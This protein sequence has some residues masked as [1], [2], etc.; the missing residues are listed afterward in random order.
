MADE[1]VKKKIL[2]VDDD[3]MTVTMM[4]RGIMNMGYEVLKGYSGQ[5]ALSI[6]KQ[7]T[8]DLIIID[9]LMPKMNGIKACALIKSDKRYRNIPV[10]ILT[11]SADDSVKKLSEEV[12][13]DAF[14][15]KPMDI[16]VLEMKIKELLKI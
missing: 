2:V 9:Q 10:I 1:V 4:S 7:N 3:L 5:E 16:H 13:A 15:N 6:I 14:C 11:A 8:V 12:G